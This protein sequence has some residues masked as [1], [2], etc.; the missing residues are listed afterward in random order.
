MRAPEEM[1]IYVAAYLMK[2]DPK[3]FLELGIGQ[4]EREREI[5]NEFERDYQH[6]EESMLIKLI[7]YIDVIFS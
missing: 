1:S 6:N 3:P 5:L 4:T 2:A 7:D